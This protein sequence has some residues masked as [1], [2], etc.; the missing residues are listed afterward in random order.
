MPSNPGSVG[1]TVVTEM[2]VRQLFV[3]LALVGF[4]AANPRRDGDDRPGPMDLAEMAIGAA[5][6]AVALLDAEQA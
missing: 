4:A 6:K 5:D 2:T 1:E 3:G